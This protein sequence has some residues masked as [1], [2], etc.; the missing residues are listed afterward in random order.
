M[1]QRLLKQLYDNNGVFKLAILTSPLFLIGLIAKLYASAIFA[2]ENFSTLFVPFVKYFTTDFTDP[3]SYFFNL[4]TLEIFP[5]P[6]L[7][8]FI[9]SVP[10]ILFAPLIGENI[11]SINHGELLL[12]HLPILLADITILV[13]LSRWL[14][15]KLQELLWFYWLSPILFYINYAHSQ[16]DVI[17]IALTFVF[18]YFLFKERWVYAL[19]FLGAAVAT[20]FHIILLLPFTII[21]LWRKRVSPIF[22]AAYTTITATVFLL[23]NNL[24]LLSPSFLTIVF[25]N[26]EQGKVF[27]LQISLGDERIIY[28]IPLAYAI[29]FL[30]ALTFKRLNRDTFVMFL[31]FSFGILIL[32]IPPMQGWY[33]WILPFFIYFYVKNEQFS[34]LP[35]VL[36]TVAYFV[37]F[38]L[39]LNSDYLTIFRV[40]EPTIASWPNLYTLIENAGFDAQIVNNIALSLLQATLLVNVLWVYRRGV[41]E[42][43][44]QKLYNMP[45]LIGIA[46][47]SGSGKSTL[48]TLLNDVFGTKHVAHV[49]GD[50]MHKWERGHTMWQ[51]FTHLDPRANQLHNDIEYA[52]A[53]QSGEDVYR[54]QYD[55]QTGTFTIPEKLESKTL[56]VFE[57][58]HAFFLTDMQKALDLK[59]FIEPEK[60]LRTH[61]KMRRDIIDRG[62]TREKILEQ[63]K[64]REH[65]ADE[66]ISIQEKYADISFTLKSLTTLGDDVIGTDI[67]PAVYLEIKCDNN[68]YLEPLLES[69]STYVN[70]EHT[71][72]DQ[73]QLLSFTGN[74][75]DSIIEHLSYALVPELYDIVAGDPKWSNNHS[76]IMQIFICYY[77]LQ[78]L[79]YSKRKPLLGKVKES[80]ILLTEI[81]ATAQEL[82]EYKSYVQGGGGNV[83]VK[84]DGVAMAVKASGLR[85]EE[86]QNTSGFVGID[87][88]TMR[89]FFNT[90]RV[91]TNLLGVLSEYEEIVALSRTLIPG[92]PDTSL[93]PSIETGFHA[94]LDNAVIHTHSVYVNILT[95]SNEGK[96]ILLK[97]FPEAAYIPYFTPGV[98]LTFAISAALK[99]CPCDTFFLE[100]HGVIVCGKTVHEA[101]Q[102]HRYINLTIKKWL[103]EVA[104][105]P[106]T[107]VTTLQNGQ[108]IS[109]Q[110][111]LTDFIKKHSAL[112]PSFTK[113][114]LFPDQVVYC[115]KFGLVG[116]NK[117]ITLD[118]TTG[119]ITYN[120]SYKEAQ[121]FIETF[122]AWIYILS[123][124]NDKNL[125]LKTIA[126][127]EGELLLGLDSE[128]YRQR[129][130]S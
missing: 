25:G 96:E 47:D 46:G 92:L 31:G 74:V 81:A 4:G 56:V 35:L 10:G 43:K 128:K 98:P 20:K 109:N 86:L 97:L 95:C 40:L 89:R 30:H 127:A 45:Y 59:I 52:K 124:I 48:T 67:E 102:K 112:I 29:L 88:V 36:L 27:D 33:Y 53:L 79:N 9:M 106:D 8:L 64:A 65:D 84:L 113:T 23:I 55:H 104:D 1:K 39:T 75:S 66:Y 125:T 42:S 14:K 24:Q 107:G 5:Y 26:R 18:L 100:N 19:V 120:V 7:M 93:R 69:L 12:F 71:F 63:M 111:K 90:P 101:A 41:E 68:I 91:I 72:T 114:I 123:G 118:M 51:K 17:P 105:F 62:Y 28:I 82:G 44:K 77:L 15:N 58:L 38:A 49:A 2:A 108:F 13:V 11:F 37:Y 121:A 22:I 103:Q 110:P 87:F 32:G 57:G 73:H 78:S 126:P 122:V 50:A 70:I 117:P 6:Q 99:Q 34:K 129:L 61:W 83:S 115:Q 54:R 94:I 80:N 119:I 3:Y 60:R 130:I 21:Y 85:L 16:L 116:E 76:G